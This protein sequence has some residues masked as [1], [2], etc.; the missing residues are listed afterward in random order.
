MEGVRVQYGTSVEIDATPD[1]VWAILMDVERWPTWTESMT[2]VDRFDHSPLAVGSRVK[3]KQPKLPAVVW[4]VTELEPGR[5][6]VWKSRA[7]GMTSVGE[8]R[9]YGD[10]APVRVTLSISQTGLVARLFSLFS[11]SMTRRYVETE[12]Q[13]LKARVERR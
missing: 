1:V 10:D 4:K 12:A 5:A 6:F 8:H 11:A 13:G 2:R 7:P 3:I 9:I